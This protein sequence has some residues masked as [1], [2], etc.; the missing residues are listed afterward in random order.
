[1]CQR[2]VHN[3][4][5]EEP[6]FL[7]TRTLEEPPKRRHLR[8]SIVILQTGSCTKCP[9]GPLRSR[10]KRQVYAYMQEEDVV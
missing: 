6:R 10:L 7:T 5:V 4:T 9:R 3:L 8:G 1:M 2:P